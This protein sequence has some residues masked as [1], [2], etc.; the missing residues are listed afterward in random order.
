MKKVQEQKLRTNKQ[1]AARFVFTNKQNHV[2][3]SCY[4]QRKMDGNR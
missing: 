3:I 2:N 1:N 4:E